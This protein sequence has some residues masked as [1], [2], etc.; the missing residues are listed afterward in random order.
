MI[1]RLGANPALSGATAAVPGAA[2][3]PAGERQGTRLRAAAD[4]PKLPTLH[5]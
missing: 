3:F 5:R 4:V 1:S 2:A